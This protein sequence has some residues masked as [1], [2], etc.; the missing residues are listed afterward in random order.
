MQNKLSS[1]SAEL[2]KDQS[3]G[4]EMRE[5]NDAGKF[6]SQVLYE[7]NYQARL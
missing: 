1:I 5:L 7:L 6:I 3:K 4:V 2:E